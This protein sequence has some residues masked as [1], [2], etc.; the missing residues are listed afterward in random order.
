MEKNKLSGEFEIEA[1]WFSEDFKNAEY[2]VLKYSQN[3]IVLELPDSN[4]EFD[5]EFSKVIGENQKDTISLFNVRVIGESNKQ[6]TKTK[7]LAEFMFIDKKPIDRLEDFKINSV[8]WS[9]D[10]LPLFLNGSVWKRLNETKGVKYS[11]IQQKEFKIEN[12]DAI[13]CINYSYVAQSKI[14]PENGIVD[15]FKTIPYFTIKYAKVKN[16]LAIKEDMR[17]I[18]NLICI[19]SGAPQ[20]ISTFKYSSTGYD[21]RD[22]K[23]PANGQF[24]FS[25]GVSSRKNFQKYSS[26]YKFEIIS[27][28]FGEV[29]TNYFEKYQELVPIIQH[30][31]TLLSYKNLLESSYVDAITSLEAFHRG[32]YDDQKEV[33]SLT[34]TTI[35]CL[36]NVVKEAYKDKVGIELKEKE[37]IL[38]HIKNM[39]STTLKERIVEVFE[40]VPIALKE[41]FKY[42]EINFLNDEDIEEFARKSVKTRNHLAHGNSKR[43]FNKDEMLSATYILSMIAESHLMSKIGLSEDLIVEGIFNT[44]V[45]QTFLYSLYDFEPPVLL[46]KE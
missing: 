2:G 5:R 25:Q 11:E 30:L 45:Y 33:T 15:T 19:L 39:N 31:T 38:L 28:K 9:T 18:C 21:L 8:D 26:A 41:K 23:M 40:K 22:R 7:L 44:K 1:K 20:V 27:E 12:L 34:K 36:K 6:L 10:K 32:F 46:E 29:L 35:N 13:L 4:L 43:I 24:Y 14:T 17:K 16:I 3:N 42:H 37:D